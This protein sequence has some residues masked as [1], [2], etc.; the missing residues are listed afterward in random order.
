MTVSAFISLFKSNFHISLKKGLSQSICHINFQNYSINFTLVLLDADV[1]SLHSKT[2]S[3]LTS[4]DSF[5]KTFDGKISRNNTMLILP[6]IIF[7]Q[8]FLFINFYRNGVAL[9]NLDRKIRK[10]LTMYKALYSRSNLD[11][12]HL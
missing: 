1:G 4:P 6:T 10:C 2:N 8:N 5:S 12:L 3:M 7:T 11:S 9:Q